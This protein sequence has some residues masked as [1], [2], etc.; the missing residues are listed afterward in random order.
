MAPAGYREGTEILNSL[1]RSVTAS[2]PGVTFLPTW[3]LLA[4]AS[5]AY[6]NAAKVNRVS[7]V[8]RASDGIHFSVIG[9][10]VLATYV[11]NEMASIYHVKLRPGE[12]AYLTP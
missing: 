1:F 5:G 8:L 2:V 10:D 9:E 11:I 4:S 6:Q 3:S 12:P 7:A